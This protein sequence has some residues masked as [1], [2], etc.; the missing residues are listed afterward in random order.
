M[1]RKLA[2]LTLLIINGVN[3]RKLLLMANS[4]KY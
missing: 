2:K 3:G 1:L 4:P